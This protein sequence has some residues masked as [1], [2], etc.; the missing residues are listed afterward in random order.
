M[1]TSA[2]IFAEL[3]TVESIL[4]SE[5]THDDVLLDLVLAVLIILRRD[6]ADAY[7]WF[8]F[9]AG[10][11]LIVFCFVAA[12]HQVGRTPKPWRERWLP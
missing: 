3:R 8:C 10:I 12:L 6:Y 11:V 5:E 2:D 7:P 4:D 1:E 9:I